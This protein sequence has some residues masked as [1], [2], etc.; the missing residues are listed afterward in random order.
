M[1]AV[2]IKASPLFAKMRAS[3]ESHEEEER[4]R[5]STD[6]AEADLS[7]EAQDW[8]ELYDEATQATYYYSPR[9]GETRWDKPVVD[10]DGWY[11]QGEEGEARGPQG[12]ESM[13][14]WFEHGYFPAG[15][16]V[17]KGGSGTFKD[18][19]EF[20]EICGSTA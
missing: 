12:L 14:S 19:Y 2:D 13:R 4:R 15:T 7:L 5:E 11:Y 8:E 20:P 1:A 18:V 3:V 17:R 9:T 10:T 16:M 6:G